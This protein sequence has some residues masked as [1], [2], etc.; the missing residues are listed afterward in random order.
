MRAGVFLVFLWF[1]GGIALAAPPVIPEAVKQSVR[2][3]VDF[4]YVPGITVVMVNPD[5]RTYFTYG[6]L[7]YDKPWATDETALYEIASVTKTFAA[8]L[9]S[10]MVEAGDVSLSDPVAGFLPA[11]VS[12]PTGG[13]TMTLEHLATH[14]SGL[15]NS[16]PNLAATIT[17]HGNQ[18]ANYFQS[19]FY[20]F[21]NTY[22]LPRA[23]GASFEYSNAGIGLLGHVLALS[24]GKDFETLLKERVL[25]PM[26]MLDTKITLSEGDEER[27]A[28]GHHG[29]VERPKFEMNI[30]APAGGLLSC[31]QDL[32][33]YLEYQL[34]IQNGTIGPA[35][36]AAHEKHFDL[37]GMP[38]DMGLGWWIWRNKGVI[39]H[40][41]D[42]HG[43]TSFVGFRD[44]TQTGVAIVSNNRGHNSLAVSDL[45]FHC[46]NQ[47]EPL[48]PILQLPAVDEEDLRDVVGR[49]EHVSGTVFN[50]GLEHGWLFLDIPGQTSYTLFHI[51]SGSQFKMLDFGL[52]A[53]VTF[54]AERMTYRQN[55]GTLLSFDRIRRDGALSL[56]R[57]GDQ[58]RLLL[59][60]EGD[61]SYPIEWSNDLN[62]WNT[63]GPRTIWDD[64]YEEAIGGAKYFRIGE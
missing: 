45:G 25:D 64:P 20:E 23:P 1:S 3:R 34:G 47:S 56:V 8:L 40:G 39:Q 13:A 12:I 42:S 58:I 21:L 35:V 32:G 16:P 18:F 38:Y 5:G 52:D 24:Q 51:S 61:L 17:D 44:S 43:S 29:V 55:G 37:P 15:P 27:R 31:G 36:Q 49:Y 30:L 4:G 33:N 63:L 9:L 41:G 28:P 60:G 2:N 6:N 57:S 50:I 46:L 7:S 48:N 62:T 10:E 53:D 54:P 11:G 19:D 59:E 22:T 14:T 26:G